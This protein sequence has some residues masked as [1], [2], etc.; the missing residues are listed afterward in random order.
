MR[1]TI[2]AISIVAL[3]VWATTITAGTNLMGEKN[4]I[5][6]FNEDDNKSKGKCGTGKC[7]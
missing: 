7:G 4:S 5:E 2:I 6:Q 1:K 3:G